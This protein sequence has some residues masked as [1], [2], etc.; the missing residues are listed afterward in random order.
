M[1]TIGNV[2]C[3]NNGCVYAFVWCRII[4]K[5]VHFFTPFLQPRV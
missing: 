3:V 4:N 5:V 1:K 2:L